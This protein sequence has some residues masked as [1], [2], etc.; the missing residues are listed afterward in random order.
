MNKHSLTA[1]ISAF[2]A[3]IWLIEELIHGKGGLVSNTVN[4][5]FTISGPMPELPFINLGWLVELWVLLA[6][7]W[8]MAVFFWMVLGL[9]MSSSGRG[10][11]RILMFAILLVPVGV[12]SAGLSP[13][14]PAGGNMHSVNVQVHDLFERVKDTF[15]IR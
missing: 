3:M 14:L 13:G 2:A 8:V 4:Q 1:A 6:V 9:C 15:D 10:L 7:V 12:S 11:Q 5:I